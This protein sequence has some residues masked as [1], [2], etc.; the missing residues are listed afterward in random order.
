MTTYW[1][2][3][4]EKLELNEDSMG[5]YENYSDHLSNDF[6]LNQISSLIFFSNFTA[7]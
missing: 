7:K 6:R 1:Y 5:V 4:F 3:G 2:F